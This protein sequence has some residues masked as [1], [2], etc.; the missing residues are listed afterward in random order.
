[1]ESSLQSYSPSKLIIAIGMGKS[2]KFIPLSPIILHFFPLC[3]K[4][5][6]SVNEMF[7]LELFEKGEKKPCSHVCVDTGE[8]KRYGLTQDYY[9]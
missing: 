3:G 5:L 9:F 8:R 2:K 1:L 6:S 4:L 7:R